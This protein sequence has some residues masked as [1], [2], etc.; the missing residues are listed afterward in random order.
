VFA[1]ERG[2]MAAIR[3]ETSGPF[4]ASYFPVPLEQV[5]NVERLLP[6]DYLEPSHRDIDESFRDYA[7][8]LL[9]GP[10]RR[11]ARLR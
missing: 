8:P 11:Y 7:E 10:L 9:S 2:F 6:Q 5:A 1:G 3:R 4:E